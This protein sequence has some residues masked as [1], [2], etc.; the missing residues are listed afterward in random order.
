VDVLAVEDVISYDPVLTL[1][2]PRA[3]ERA[4]VLVPWAQV[5]PGFVVPGTGATVESL[6]AALPSEAV[7][8]VRPL[9]AP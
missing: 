4:F 9:E 7:A 3:A 5:D 6:M 1:P 2:H 8:Q